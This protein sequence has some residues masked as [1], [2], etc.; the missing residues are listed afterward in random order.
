M[1]GVDI[2]RRAIEE[3]VRMIVQNAGGEGLIAVE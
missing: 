1:I 3:P 2:I